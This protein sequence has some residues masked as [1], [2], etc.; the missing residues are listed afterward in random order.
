VSLRGKEA[1]LSLRG[2][3][4]NRTGRVMLMEKNTIREKIKELRAEIHS[5]AEITHR[6]DNDIDELN[7]ALVKA[8]DR[9]DF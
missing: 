2:L 9:F 1:P 6:Y 5:L 7:A 4:R 8:Y 3:R